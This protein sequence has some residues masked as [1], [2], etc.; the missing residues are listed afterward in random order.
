MPAF[1]PPPR[2]GTPAGQASPP[3]EGI[4]ADLG[5]GAVVARESRRR[6]LNRDGSFNVRREGP[7]PL[8]ALN[9]YHYLLTV[10][11]AE[12][13]AIVTA[14]YLL[15]NTAFAGAYLLCGPGAL[16]GPDGDGLGPFAQAFFF[17]VETFA[18][19]GYGNIAPWGLA[20]NRVMVVE[21]LVGLLGFALATGLLFARFSRPT[22]AIVFSRSALVA[23]Y[24]GG[25]AFEF[26]IVNGRTNQLVEVGAR[27][28]FSRF[29]PDGGGARQFTELKLERQ[30]VVFF[31]L[32]WTVVHPIDPESPLYGLGPD[33]LQRSDAEF[34]ILLT[35]TDETFSQMVHTRTSYKPDEIVWG[36]RFA[37]LF[38]PPAP[39]GTLS[40]DMRRLHAFDRVP[41]PEPMREP[42]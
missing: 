31:P 3:M 28:L 6:L 17:S 1:T 14:V 4:D 36:A 33:D 40:I 8:S 2:P 16:R 18:T 34:L 29:G 32:A 42:A 25:T 41:L 10:S 21:S 12:F 38:N 11:W 26:R 19:I 15:V 9:L 20:A 35:A 7:R 27:V 24:R 39:D 5:F 30:H 37:N 13:L 23:P 22:A